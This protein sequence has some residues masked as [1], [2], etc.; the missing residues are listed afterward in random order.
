MTTLVTAELR[1]VLTLRF[2]WALVLAPIVVAL[3]AGSIYAALADGLGPVDTDLSTEAVSIGMVVA[4][5]GAALFAG[6]FGAVTAGTE[7]RHRTLTPTFLT[8]R[9]RDRVLAAK[10]A[11][12]ALFGLGYAVAVEVVA[13]ACMVVFG[14]E[15]FEVTPAIL[16]MLGSG[17]LATVAWSLIGAGLALLVASPTG[18]VVALAIWYPVGELVTIATLTGMGAEPVARLFPGAATW[19]T[20]VSPAGEVDGFLPW[21]AAAT[22]LCA[23]AA[24]TAGLG[25]WTSRGRDVV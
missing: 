6:F 20:V 11:V 19:S 17:L 23:W 16:G 24:A 21:P 22:T 2:W 12:V 8:T 3:F 7:F 25:W 18:A 4:I 9:G 5:G 10:L 14:G 13:L 15:S 1:K